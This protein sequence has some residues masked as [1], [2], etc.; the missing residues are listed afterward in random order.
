ML[1]AIGISLVTLGAIWSRGERYDLYRVGSD[2]LQD[3]RTLIEAAHGAPAPLC[4]LAARAVGNGW[5][6]WG[7]AP[8]TPLGKAAD[9]PIRMNRR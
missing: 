6:G 7:D 3:I 5:G 1:R 4:A 2:A 8:V 9:L